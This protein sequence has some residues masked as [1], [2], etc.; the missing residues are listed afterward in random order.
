VIAQAGGL[1]VASWLMLAQL[2]VAAEPPAAEP[3]AVAA[4]PAAV[5][6]EAAAGHRQHP[7]PVV[8]APGYADLEFEPPA[9]GSYQLPPFGN[10]ADG[11]V[12]RADGTRVQLDELLGDKVVILSFIFT[13]CSD[14]NGCPLATFVLKGVQEKILDN[15]DIADDVRLLSLSFDP[16]HDTPAVMRAYGARFVQRSFDWQFL[17]CESEQTLAPILEH[18]DQWV[19]KDYDADGN[20]LATLSHVLRVY[21]IDRERRIRNIYSVSFLHADTLVSDVRTILLEEPQ[22]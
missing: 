10:A 9:P 4:E 21:L 14:V 3:A 18:Y 20:Y 22:R 6:A 11:E 13:T 5:A 12:L 19:I 7:K 1:L 16:G 17:T 8:L 2:A 15:A